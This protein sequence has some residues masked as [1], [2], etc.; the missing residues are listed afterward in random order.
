MLVSGVRPAGEA[1]PALGPMDERPL[2]L[3]VHD[4]AKA[5]GPT[6]A[7]RACSFEL[8]AGEVHCIV[9]ENG[10]GKSTL[11]KILAGVHRP[12]SGTFDVGG[13]TMKMLKSPQASLAA[14][15]SVVFQEVLVVEPRSVLENVW[16][17]T[18]ELVRTNTPQLLARPPVSAFFL[19]GFSVARP[20]CVRKTV[21]Q[22]RTAPPAPNPRAKRKEGPPKK[23]QKGLFPPPPHQPEPVQGLSLSHRQSCCI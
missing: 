1:D 11:V 2:A 21:G 20:P 12:D 3:R 16:L 22:A 17:G 4:L 7:L 6:Q 9:G 5:F 14:G 8:R 15:I 23:T 10:S 19:K 18:D 13:E